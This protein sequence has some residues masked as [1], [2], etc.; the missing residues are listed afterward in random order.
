MRPGFGDDGPGGASMKAKRRDSAAAV[1]EGVKDGSVVLI[2]GFAISG[3]PE[4]LMHALCD[5]R[6]RGLT[7]VANSPGGGDNWIGR[8]VK[9]GCV[10]KV[11]CSFPYAGD[12][13]HFRELYNKGEIELDL[14][15]QGTL[16]ERIRAGGAGLGGFL[17]PTGV[18]TDVAKGKQVI[19][20]DGKPHLLEKAI[21][22][23]VALVL[24]EK[25][26]PFGNLTYRKAARNFNAVMAKSADLVLVQAVEEVP[27]GTFDPAAIVTPGIFVDRYV[28]LGGQ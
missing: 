10:A 25:V 13:G 5:I 6:P 27:L 21:R 23:D 2:G 4:E 22:G 8:L 7:I 9:E 18:G 24:A 20:V 16:A 26:D 14:A 1:V 3:M 28:V 19:E 11:I 17:T 12:A 15:P